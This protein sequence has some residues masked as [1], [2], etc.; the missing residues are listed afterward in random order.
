MKSLVMLVRLGERELLPSLEF[1]AATQFG[2]TLSNPQGSFDSF[3]GTS[4]SH[5]FAIRIPDVARIADE[6]ERI[7]L[8]CIVSPVSMPSICR[9]AIR[10]YSLH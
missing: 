5:S 3:P 10:V 8:L 4:R 1:V 7:L 2:E 6:H 9:I